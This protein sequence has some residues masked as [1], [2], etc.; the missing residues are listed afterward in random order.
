LTGKHF[1]PS[2]IQSPFHHGLVIVFTLAIAM[3]LVAALFSAFRGTRYIHEEHTMHEH[4]GDMTLSG[5]AVPGEPAMESQ[6]VR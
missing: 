6:V 2:L 5:G 1:F 3:S 4:V